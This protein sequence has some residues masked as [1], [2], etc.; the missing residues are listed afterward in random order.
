LFVIFHLSSQ[1]KKEAKV[2]L[3]KQKV[4][5]VAK[6]I[7]LAELRTKYNNF[8]DRRD[9]AARYTHFVADDRIVCMLP[10]TL[11]RAFYSG[12]NRPL[13][14]RLAQRSGPGA[15]IE[16]R[17]QGAIKQS[18]FYYTGG[19]CT[20]VRVGHTALSAQEISENVAAVVKCLAHSQGD[21]RPSMVPRGW[22]GIQ[23]LH[24]KTGKSVALPVYAHLNPA[25]T[26]K[27]FKT[28]L[29]ADALEKTTSAKVVKA[30]KTE[31]K[32]KTDESKKRKR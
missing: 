14:I 7:E 9:L 18:A 17:I 13:P 4:S 11:G 22:T 28:D 20:V 16:Q 23:S 5:C 29:I 31:T 10:K 19:S 27:V 12:Q 6:V 30:G 1:D 8:T 25:A 2:W 21:N 32:A 15:G 26:P 3:E 24:I